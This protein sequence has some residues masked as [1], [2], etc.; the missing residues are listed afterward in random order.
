MYAGLLPRGLYLSCSIGGETS[1]QVPQGRTGPNSSGSIGTC[2]R[3]APP[4]IRGI[5]EGAGIGTEE[6]GY[7]LLFVFR[8]QRTFTKR[9]S[10][11]IGNCSR[12]LPRTPASRR[13]RFEFQ[14]S[15]GS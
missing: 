9:I 2:S 10:A 6:C 5:A 3:E 1:A 7:T 12:L 14:E 4:S 11:A 8:L 13:G 15:N